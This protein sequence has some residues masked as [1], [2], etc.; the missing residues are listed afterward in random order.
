MS[1]E[2]WRAPLVSSSSAQSSESIVGPRVTRHRVRALPLAAPVLYRRRSASAREVPVV[3]L[4][5]RLTARAGHGHELVQALRS[6]MRQAVIADGCSDAH[7]AAD[8]DEANAFWYVETWNSPAAT[9]AQ[10]GT[11]RFA[12]LLAL[13]ETAAAPP[14]VEFRMIRE[15]RG[16]EYVAAVRAAT[17]SGAAAAATLVSRRR[18]GPA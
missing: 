13:L 16:L 8:V 17:H 4:T 18:R 15:T 3:Q 10:L 2:C 9:E 6:I 11:E 14:V 12:H 1:M 7:I 5:V